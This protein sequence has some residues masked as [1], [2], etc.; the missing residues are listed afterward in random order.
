MLT[1]GD[2]EVSIDGEVF[3]PRE[4]RNHHADNDGEIPSD[5]DAIHGSLKGRSKDGPLLQT[6]G[7]WSAKNQA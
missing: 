3:I 2:R 6:W 4:K 1:V 5:A 7:I